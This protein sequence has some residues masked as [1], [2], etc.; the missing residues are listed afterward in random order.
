MT[1]RRQNITIVGRAANQRIE[2]AI[3]RI[4]RE[5][6]YG[7]RQATAVAIRMESAGQLAITG[8]PVTKSQM[9][10]GK[11]SLGVFATSQLLR[12][13]QPKK[14]T[15]RQVDPTPQN[16]VGQYAKAY[17]AAAPLMYTTKK[18]RTK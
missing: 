4:Q 16:S 3:P 15:K 5:L 18:K 2:T 10:G 11:L 13:R 14:T 17:F 8:K 12:K 6:G 1:K 7:K 9:L